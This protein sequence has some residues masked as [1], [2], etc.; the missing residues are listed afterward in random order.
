MASLSAFIC[1]FCCCTLN[2]ALFGVRND[3]AAAAAA[4]AC[5]CCWLRTGVVQLAANAALSVF[6]V[7][8][9]GVS[10][11]SVGVFSCCKV[12]V[13]MIKL[14]KQLLAAEAARRP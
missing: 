7:A 9:S 10:A 12:G 13:L 1:S 8:S 5:C 4:T 14:E 2:V 11:N 6:R 3:E